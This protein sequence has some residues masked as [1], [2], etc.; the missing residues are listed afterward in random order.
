MP[1]T[2]PNSGVASTTQPTSAGFSFAPTYQDYSTYYGG[3]DPS[4]Y[5]NS[6]QPGLATQLT[7]DQWGAL[8]PA[9]QW[10]ALGGRLGI[11]PSDPRYAGLLQQM[12]QTDANGQPVVVR[13]GSPLDPSHDFT[14]PNSVLSGGGVQAYLHDNMTPGA[15]RGENP[16]TQWWQAPL[17]GVG[18][19]GAELA[20]AGAAGLFGGAAGSGLATSGTAAAGEFGAEDT[21]LSMANPFGASGSLGGGGAGGLTGDLAAGTQ[22]AAPVTDL[23]VSAAPG[24]ALSSAGAGSGSSILS[25]L[26]QGRSILGAISALTGGTAAAGG[27]GVPSSTDTSSNGVLGSLLGI[28][29]LGATARSTGL[30]GGGVGT[31]SGAQAAGAQAAAAADPFGASGL[32]TQAQGML[33]P[34]T[35]SSLLGLDSTG[36]N[37]AI[38]SDPGYQFALQQGVGAINQGDAAQGTL[39]SGNRGT[40]LAQYGTGLAAQYETQYKQNNLA[41]LGA[42]GSLAGNNSSSPAT[43]GNDIISGFTGATNLQNGGINSLLGPL[44]SG[45]S[46]ALAGLGGSL[47]SLLSSAGGGISSFLSSIFGGSSGGVSDSDLSS[48]M[49]NVTNVGSTLAQGAG[50]TA[51]E[52]FGGDWGG[53]W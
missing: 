28:L 13:Y 38:T 17:V 45:S 51:D 2:Q 27:S 48:L 30:I 37:A 46:G 26:N 19:L 21:G 35:M 41:T 5:A 47:T 14:N 49:G 10:N 22:A 7:Q 36:A 6:A 44:L 8:D 31:P 16:T 15:E 11:D 4:S 25:Q 33:T 52:L 23:G 3:I 12:G 53:G 50:N 20:T 18:V 32:R 1:V 43:A 42:L 40:E 9:G 39:R 24:S 29:G 34:G